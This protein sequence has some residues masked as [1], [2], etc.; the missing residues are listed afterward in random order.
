MRRELEKW[1]PDASANE[2]AT[3]LLGKQASHC[4]AVLRENVGAFL[5][6]RGNLNFV[7]AK[8]D[9]IICIVH[10]ETDFDSRLIFKDA[11]GKS[12]VQLL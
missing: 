12:E 10:G 11:S 8:V 3:V 7:D 2:F 4:K 9:G 5:W 1:S 6:I